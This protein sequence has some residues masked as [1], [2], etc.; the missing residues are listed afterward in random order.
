MT[1]LEFLEL[2]ED[3]QKYM[4]EHLGIEQLKGGLVFRKKKKAA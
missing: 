4:C 1:L 3:E 2:D